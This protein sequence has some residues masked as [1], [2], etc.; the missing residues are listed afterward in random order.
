MARHS[1]FLVAF[2]VFLLITKFSDLL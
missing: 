2:F 1:T